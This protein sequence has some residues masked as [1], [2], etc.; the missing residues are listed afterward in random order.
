[1]PGGGTA[2]DAIVG[3]SGAPRTEPGIWPG[4][5][6][7]IASGGGRVGPTTGRA[8][9]AGIGTAARIAVLGGACESRCGR[10]T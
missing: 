9:R 7:G 4:I 1:M 10:G 3:R 8:G 5:G 6:L 2:G